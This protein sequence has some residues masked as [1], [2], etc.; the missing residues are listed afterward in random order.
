VA[1]VGQY[2]S[3][4]ISHSNNN[5]DMRIVSRKALITRE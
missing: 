5:I 4:L 1:Y 3:K 2:I